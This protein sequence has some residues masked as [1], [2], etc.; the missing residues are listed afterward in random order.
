MNREKE[1]E[2]VIRYRLHRNHPSKRWEE[3]GGNWENN[4]VSVEL[5]GVEVLKV[6]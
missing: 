5:E 1:D 2:E 3:R 4:N 6:Y